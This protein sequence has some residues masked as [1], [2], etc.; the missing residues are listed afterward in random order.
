M[1]DDRQR[2]TTSGRV[3]E[4]KKIEKE[5]GEWLGQKGG[6]E[7]IGGKSWS[8]SMSKVIV[9]L[10]HDFWSASQSNG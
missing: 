10:V 2:P 9:D 4:G 5:G 8:R 3:K 1:V 6:M 7:E